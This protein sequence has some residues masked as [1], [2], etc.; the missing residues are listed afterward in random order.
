[1]AKKDK[2]GN[3]SEEN[4]VGPAVQPL[5]F[6]QEKKGDRLISRCA[7]TRLMEAWSAI[8]KDGYTLV[9]A[10]ISPIR[11]VILFAKKIKD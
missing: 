6:N 2:E 5:F 10:T 11:H 3:K 7:Q 8:E 4:M 9:A 1:M